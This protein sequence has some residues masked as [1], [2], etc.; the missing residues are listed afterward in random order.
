[1]CVVIIHSLSLAR[2]TRALAK[3]EAI[4]RPALLRKIL[5]DRSLGPRIGN[6]RGIAYRI[7]SLQDTQPTLRYEVK[8]AP[9]LSSCFLRL[10]F[11]SPASQVVVVACVCV[12]TRAP[13]RTRSRRPSRDIKSR[14]FPQNAIRKRR[15]PKD[16]LVGAERLIPRADSRHCLFLSFALRDADAVTFPRTALLVNAMRRRRRRRVR[17]F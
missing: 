3:I 5:A 17:S 6:T 11:L 4:G 9:Q 1:M 7:H 10:N 14:Y 2:P 12:C 13:A 15:E 16:A 8:A